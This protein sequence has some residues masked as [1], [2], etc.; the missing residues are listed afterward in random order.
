MTT[1]AVIE[2]NLTELNQFLDKIRTQHHTFATRTNDCGKN[3]RL[4]VEVGKEV[5]FVVMVEMTVVYSGKNK[6]AAIESYLFS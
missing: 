4:V 3:V 5:E 6:E 2:K 1:T